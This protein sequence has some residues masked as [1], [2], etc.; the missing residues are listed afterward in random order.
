[1][2]KE[3]DP[4]TRVIL[5]GPGGA[6][7]NQAKAQELAGCSHLL[8]ICGHYEGV[9]ERIHFY[10][11]VGLYPDKRPAELFITVNGGTEMLNGWCKVWAIA[12]SLCLQSGITVEKLYEKFAH[13]DFEPKGF[14]ESE[15]IK[16]CSSV[17]DYVMEFMKRRFIN[18]P[19][20]AV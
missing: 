14:T 16:S 11:V 7:F 4:E 2:A 15:D 10:I 12:I 6:A 8:L 1:M 20:E 18:P 13:Q 19:K 17:V 3:L 5:L 9:D